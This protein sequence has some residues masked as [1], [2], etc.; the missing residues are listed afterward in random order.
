MSTIAVNTQRRDWFRIIRDLSKEGISAA[1]IGRKCNRDKCTVIG[2]ANG[3]EPKESDARI[4]LAIY[5]KYCPDKFAAHQ[6]Q[7]EIRV[8]VDARFEKAADVLALIGGS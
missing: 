6:R 1:E 8:G 2:W 5:A 7:F 4:V 3:G